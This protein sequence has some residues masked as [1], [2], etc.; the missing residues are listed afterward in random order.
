MCAS[1]HT[2]HAVCGHGCGHGHGY[3]HGCHGHGYGHARGHAVTV[4]CRSRTCHDSFSARSCFRVSESVRSG[5]DVLKEM[6]ANL[7]TPCTIWMS[8]P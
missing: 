3:G 5:S 8:E 1:I 7:T 6:E 4:N 2:C